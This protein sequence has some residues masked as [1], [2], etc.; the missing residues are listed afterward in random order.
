MTD[1]DIIK[2][3]AK[4]MG[5]VLEYR[6]G[7]DAFYYDDLETGREAWLPTQDDRQTM[8]IIA[9][10]RMD[11]CCL[12]HLARATAHVPYVGFKKS[13][14]PH[15]D[16]PG[17]RRNALRLAVATVAAKYGQGMLDGGTDER[18]LGHLLG[19][20][21]STA[22]AMRGTIRESREEISKA[23]RRLKRKGL[24]TNKGPFRQAVQR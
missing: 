17:A 12:H 8:L 2:L 20:E 23:C 14:V 22:H 13:E 18:V 9:K 3:S 15:A 11:I 6:R 5:F 10:L 16:N 19:I 1:E 7:S 21:G 24:V 4:A